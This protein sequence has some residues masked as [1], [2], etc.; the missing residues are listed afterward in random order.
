MSRICRVLCITVACTVSAVASTSLQ[1]AVLTG[2]LAMIGFKISGG[3]EVSFVAL[4][5]IG[6]GEQFYFADAGVDSVGCERHR[7]RLAV[8]FDRHQCRY[9]H[10]DDREWNNVDPVIRR[11]R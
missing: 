6:A 4:N 11:P 7:G 2:D 9:C 5:D 3:D 10:H 8:Q 1:A